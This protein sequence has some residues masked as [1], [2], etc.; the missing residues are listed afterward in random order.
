MLAGLKQFELSNS[1]LLLNTAYNLNNI[2]LESYT[3]LNNA[4]CSNRGAGK[5]CSWLVETLI[6]QP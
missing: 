1:S 6:Y 3:P 4:A 2:S 5:K